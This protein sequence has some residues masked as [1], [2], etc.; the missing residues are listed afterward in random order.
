MNWALSCAEVDQSNAA[1]RDTWSKIQGRR[2]LLSKQLEGYAACTEDASRRDFLL[3]SPL[4]LYAFSHTLC[5]ND[6]TGFVRELEL[7]LRGEVQIRKKHQV[8]ES[9]EDREHLVLQHTVAEIKC[10]GDR[11]DAI[12]QA[13]ALGSSEGSV[14]EARQSVPHRHRRRR[15][16]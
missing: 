8:V 9:E 3:R 15:L 12:Q 6:Q 7:D 13:E 10:G 4:G 5:T 11:S 1:G 14:R 2:S 16:R